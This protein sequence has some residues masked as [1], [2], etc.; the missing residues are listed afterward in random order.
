MCIRDRYPAS[1]PIT[2]IILHLSCE[3]DV[4]R[5]LSIPSIAVFTAVSK[6][7]RFIKNFAK[8][9]GNEAGKALVAAGPKL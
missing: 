5:T 1:R 2:S 4:S 3:V 7:G 9:T 8:F 6:P